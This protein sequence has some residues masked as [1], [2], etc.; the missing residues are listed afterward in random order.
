MSSLQLALLGPFALTE[1]GQP[2]ELNIA[3][4]QALLAYLAITAR[5]QRREQILAQL[6][7][8]SHPDAA[9][10][11][12]RNRLWQLRQLTENDLVV[13]DGDII[14]LAAAV[15]RDTDY[16]VAGIEEQLQAPRID[17]TALTKLLDLWRG[18]LLEGLQ[19][20]EAPDFELW[21]AQQQE[22]FGQRYL[23]AIRALIAYH[24]AEGNWAE[25][26]ALAL[27]GLAQDPLHEPLYQQLMI[28]YAQ[29]GQRSEALRIYEQLQTIL[30]T[31]LAAHPL[32][33]TEDLR[34]KI[35]EGHPVL[36]IEESANVWATMHQRT[37]D[38][39]QS[40]SLSYAKTASTDVE[41][42]ATPITH[43]LLPPRA[44]Q[45]FIGRQAELDR[46][47]AAFHRGRQ[48]DCRVLLISG[49]LGMGK[50]TLWQHWL[51][52]FPIAE[53]TPVV[54]ATRCLNT[55]QT[56]PFEP[57]RRLL[58]T[59]RCR[60]QWSRMADEL[61]PIWQ[62]E[63]LRLAPTLQSTMQS[64]TFPATGSPP[65]ETNLSTTQVAVVPA[66]LPPNEERG[67]I[68]EALTQFLRAFHG[69]PLVLFLDDLHWAD[70][71]TLDWLLYLTDRMMNEPLLLVATYRP[72]EVST[73]LARLIAQWQRDGISERVDL[74]HFSESETIALLTDLG[75]DETVMHYLHIQSGGNPYYLTQ[76]SDVAV[77]GIPATLV[78]L[79]QTR[80]RYI[81]ERW[82]PVLQAAA[83]LE[84]AI[85][86]TLLGITSGRG[87]E[88]TIDAIDALL[89]ASILLEQGDEYEFTHPLVA[90][91]MRESLSNG[92]RKLL[93]RRAAEALL[94]RYSEHE[95]EIAGQLAHHFGA[96]GEKQRAAHFAT[97][98]GA[99]ALRIGAD[100]EAVAFYSQAQQLEP[101]PERQ[102]GL[103]Q[104]VQLQPG[105]VAEARQNM[106][107]ALAG[108]EEA[109]DSR[110]AIKAGLHL[111]ASYLGT[112]EGAQVLH[113]ARRV[114]PDLETVDDAI[115]HATAQYLMGTAQF[116]NGYALSEAETHFAAAIDL[117]EEE[118][119]DSEIAL[120]SLFE[121]GNLC[122]ERG[123]Y[124]TA[125]IK[126]EQ[127]CDFARQRQN[128]FFEALALNN[129]AYALLNNSALPEAQNSV[130]QGLALV[131]TYGL[132]SIH[133]YLL[134]TEGEIALAIGA[135][136]EAEAAFQQAMELAQKYD[137]PTFVANLWAHRGRVKQAGG[138]LDEASKYLEHAQAMVAQEKVLYLQLR[139]DLWLTAVTIEQQHTAV[140]ETYL[141]SVNER[142]A[143]T[144]YGRLKQF[145]LQLKLQLERLRN[146]PLE[147]LRNTP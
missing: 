66:R 123:D 31:E 102:L 86:F 79:V 131:D 107:T 2:V 36:A 9:R 29:Q 47:T 100:N 7:S 58:G 18:P 12:L 145:A 68:A 117:V 69:T 134:S 95:N 13:A 99:E 30:A 132:R 14:T 81:D 23:H 127:A 67:Q 85:D 136:D 128:I 16:F 108:Y 90:T 126:F 33:K 135:L 75:T 5:P 54:L 88:E 41:K 48:G 91:V 71:A 139:I 1:D 61:S 129:L 26:I 52:H 76:L 59:I 97:V 94:T 112:Q 104:A 74:P 144:E 51:N 11:N 122:L 21:L 62:A 78:D 39:T 92:R 83:I 142:L 53:S 42:P 73:D 55:T 143:S 44:A 140:S 98:A 72:S 147:R 25:V 22:Q 141:R 114:L 120:M 32:A 146:T 106:E 40:R 63:L 15:Q 138:A 80:L 45:P 38:G 46:L 87:E 113:W 137:N 105:K 17:P 125:I 89:G 49:E 6:W 64:T 28:A 3:K 56:L 84:P 124:A 57:M 109:A 119:L 103:G 60:D 118:E 35:V 101:T 121:W 93:H 27:R 20:H 115:L 4:V 43:N 133:Y 96:A 130:Q 110:G 70:G 77:D 8:E 24:T 19:L 37:G 34:R 111:A 65:L 116:R 50:T 10:K 82:Q